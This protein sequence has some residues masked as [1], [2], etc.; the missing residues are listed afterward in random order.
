MNEFVMS[1]TQRHFTL[2]W[3]AFRTNRK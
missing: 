2:A 3:Y 1:N